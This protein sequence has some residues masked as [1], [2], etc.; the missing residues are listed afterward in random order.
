MASFPLFYNTFSE[1]VSFE[2]KN[3]PSTFL[4]KVVSTDSFLIGVSEGTEQGVG[5]LIHRATNML[6]Q[7][8]PRVFHKVPADLGGSI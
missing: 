2:V 7:H 8:G 3:S 1:V 6:A 4:G 5:V